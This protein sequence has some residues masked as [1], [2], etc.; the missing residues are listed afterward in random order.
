MCDIKTK[1]S[2]KW[3]FVVPPARLIIDQMTLP[4]LSFINHNQTGILLIIRQSHASYIWLK[5]ACWKSAWS[6]WYFSAFCGQRLVAV[7]GTNPS[8]WSIQLSRHWVFAAVAPC[9]YNRLAFFNLN[10]VW[11]WY[12]VNTVQYLYLLFP[13]ICNEVCNNIICSCQKGNTLPREQNGECTFLIYNDRIVW[14]RLS[15]S[16]LSHYRVFNNTPYFKQFFLSIGALEEVNKNETPG[17]KVAKDTLDIF[18]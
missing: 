12:N 1:T 6:Y 10:I 9:N 7:A 13:V 2:L 17:L 11:E 15:L 3:L 8:P 4:T 16:L 18:F 5:I 14:L